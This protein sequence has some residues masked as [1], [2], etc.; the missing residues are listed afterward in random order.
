MCF[1]VHERVGKGMK[2]I[3]L[4]CLIVGIGLSSISVGV[5]ADITNDTF[6]IDQYNK[7][8]SEAQR[9]KRIRAALLN[10]FAR[11]ADNWPANW[12]ELQTFYSDGQPTSVFGTPWV[13]VRNGNTI[14]LSV[15]T[16]ETRFATYLANVTQGTQNGTS[17][18]LFIDPPVSLALNDRYLARKVIPGSPDANLMEHDL[19]MGN[20][21]I[22]E[23]NNITGA[24]ATFDDLTLTNSLTVPTINADELTVT[25]TSTLNDVN[26]QTASIETLANT[27]ANIQTATINT[28]TATNADFV[29]AVIDETATNKLTVNGESILNGP[30]TVN[31]NLTVAGALTTSSIT[32]NG[33]Y[34]GQNATLSGNLTA[35]SGSIATLDFNTA[36]G[37]ALDL[38][39]LNANSGFVGSL[40][41][42]GMRT[43]NYVDIVDSNTR[44]TKGGG[45]SL[46]VSTNSGYLEIGARNG[47]Y[48]HFI[49]DRADFYFNKEVQAVEGFRVYNTDTFLHN[50]RLNLMASGNPNMELRSTNG[51]TPYL[52][53][54]NDTTVDYDMRLILN[55]NDELEVS[56]GFLKGAI[57]ATDLRIDD[58]YQIDTNNSRLFIA[59]YDDGTWQYGRE[60]GYDPNINGWYSETAFRA[61]SF[62]DG[63]SYNSIDLKDHGN[64]A[65]LRNQEGRY[66]FQGGT[67]GDDWTRSFEIYLG[68][69]DNNGSNDRW[70][71]IGQRTSN[72]TNGEYRGVQI[73]KKVS[74]GTV[75]GDLLVGQV[76]INNTNTR[77]AEGSNDSVRIS[78]S[79]GYL[80]IGA[81]NADWAHFVTDRDDFYFNKEINAVTGF[82]VY[83][84]GTFLSETKLNLSAAGSTGA[85]LRS[86]NGGT[87][88]IDF[89]NDSSIDYDMRIRLTGNDEL[90]IEGGTLV[91]NFKGNIDG[92]SNSTRRVLV[93]DTR[94]V[95]SPPTTYNKEVRFDFKKR[96]SISNPAGDALYTGLMT[97]A[98][99]SENGGHESY[100][101]VFSNDN[102]SARLS[103]RTGMP[104][105]A[106]WNAWERIL[107]QSESDARYIRRSD[108]TIKTSGYDSKDG[109]AITSAGRIFA[110][111][112]SDPYLRMA[113]YSSNNTLKG[114]GD[115]KYDGMDDK[116]YIPNA[117]FQVSN[118]L[119]VKG[120]GSETYFN[121]SGSNTEE[122]RS[123]KD[124]WDAAMSSS[125]R[126]YASG[127][128]NTKGYFELANGKILAYGI[129]TTYNDGWYNIT[130]PYEFG[131][132]CFAQLSLE[133]MG[134]ATCSGKTL[135]FRRGP[136]F[137]NDS[138]LHYLVIGDKKVPSTGG[139]GGGGTTEDELCN[140]KPWMCSNN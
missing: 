62:Y 6:E 54:S 132:T 125:Q 108:S 23:L 55:G 81:Q 133:S 70:V 98:P 128:T 22:T 65:W 107:V 101:M 8:R 72:A 69:P 44:L 40:V 104:D 11:N 31:D 48:A 119:I 63:A 39:T 20:N 117:N 113:E 80:D 19:R 47:S 41:T 42:N 74:T 135:R 61:P 66:V 134:R 60:F 21:D 12:A 36:T 59:P 84:T 76:Y 2:A 127:G 86:T 103:V 7:V 78:T 18:T 124:I 57:K 118:N 49:T 96:T 32:N 25:G 116:F 109:V 130:L 91:G 110:Y 24:T 28:L 90:R 15:E 5:H 17:V 92:M 1:D 112:K 29:T 85:E 50:G 33:D 56:G 9:A 126:D 68:A 27:T 121:V 82:R 16:G 111:G 106:A 71:Q 77:I 83:G 30:T 139:G 105:S 64:A 79:N 35:S 114:S 138:D 140:S 123:I 87:P 73:V 45:N 13:F 120:K 26:I 75:S 89:S 137:D 53:F 51:G 46:R 43:N 129:F 4:L 3:G 14:E 102:G 95:N 99:W 97:F 58:L 67:A 100:Q 131:G 34:I 10:Y 93:Y 88:F 38:N 52:D 136:V 115:L 37:D 122:L 94:L